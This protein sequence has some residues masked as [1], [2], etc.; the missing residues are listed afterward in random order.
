MAHILSHSNIPKPLHGVNPRSIMGAKM[1][2][3]VRQTAYASTDF[4]CIS[5]GVHK[6]NAQK[7]QWL[8]AH[9]D[10]DID[11]AAQTVTI[12]RI[13]PL[14]HYCHAFIHSG[15]LLINARSGKIQFSEARRI[16]RHGIEILKRENSPIF[17]GTKKMAIDAGIACDL[18]VVSVPREIQW[19][20]WRM[21]W[22][23]TEYPQKFKTYQ[24]WKKHYS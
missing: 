6:A 13:I 17:P 20:G 22:N 5:C 11:Y 9:E 10:H 16:L 23:G 18:P 4:H 19:A 15:L 8:E 24:A 12:K 3:E 1:W 21:I 7:H 14:C 2:D